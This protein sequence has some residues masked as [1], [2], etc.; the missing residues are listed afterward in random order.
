MACSFRSGL[1]RVDA[2]A[3]YGTKTPVHDCQKPPA[4]G[5]GFWSFRPLS[6][7]SLHNCHIL[8]MPPRET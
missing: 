3:L 5:R 6:L 2:G 4:D 7:L 1:G 8:R